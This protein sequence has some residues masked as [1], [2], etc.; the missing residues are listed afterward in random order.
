M[1]SLSVSRT[2]YRPDGRECMPSSLD[3]SE[4]SVF[5]TLVVVP[6]P[7]IL[8]GEGPAGTMRRG[9]KDPRWLGWR[10]VEKKDIAQGQIVPSPLAFFQL[11]TQR[12]FSDMH[13][14]TMS[15]YVLKLGAGCL[16]GLSLPS[17]TFY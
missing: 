6:S 11:E 12:V 3:S 5:H 4:L 17:C 16:G 9:H 14:S 15:N 7:D 1:V 13:R 10:M 2:S 8:S